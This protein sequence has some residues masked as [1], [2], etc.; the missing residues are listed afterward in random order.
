MQAISWSLR[1]GIFPYNAKIASVAL[2]DKRKPDIYDVLNYRPVNILNA[3]TKVN[4]K[5][6]KNQLVP[7]FDTYFS[8]STSAY[9]KGYSTQQVLIP[10]LEEWREIRQELYC[11]CNLTVF[12]TTW[13]LLN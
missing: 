13:L 12:V 7:Y 8:P 10:L 3:F 5:I 1:R 4:E 9:R 11:V 2:L 6:I